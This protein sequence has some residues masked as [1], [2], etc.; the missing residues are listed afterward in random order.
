MQQ[1]DECN[2]WGEHQELDNQENDHAQEKEIQP[3]NTKS[4]QVI[5]LGPGEFSRH[6]GIK[7]KQIS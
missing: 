4:T 1:S 7:N 3:Q 6:K 2:E 5:R